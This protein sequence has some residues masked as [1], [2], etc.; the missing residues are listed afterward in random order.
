MT[1]STVITHAN[2]PGA[3]KLSS[4]GRSL[5]IVEDRIAADGEIL[6]KSDLVFQ[7]YYK[8]PEA[9]AETI[10][11]GWLHTGDIGRKDDDGFLYIM[12]RKKHIII[13]AGGKNLTPANIENE[14]KA[15]DPLI[16]QAHAHGDKRKFL[17]ALVTLGAG[18]SVEWARQ[19]GAID[20]PTADKHI[21]ALSENPL[22]RSK[23]L[24][25]LI[26]EVSESPDVQQR[27][28]ASVKRANEG[29]AKVETIKK[30]FILDRELSVEQDELTPTL[31]MKR[32]NIE[33]KFAETFDRLYEDDAFGLVVI[34]S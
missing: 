3:T 20:G 31:K 14:V 17:V 21:R 25:S 27:V 8:N 30:I 34:E 28:V 9:T 32:K 6:I 33:T 13:T 22:A 4:V 29:L 23:E 18:E 12:D 5:G 26:R 24:E 15:S 11:D 19:Q 10:V 2:A 16:S 7:G 1:E